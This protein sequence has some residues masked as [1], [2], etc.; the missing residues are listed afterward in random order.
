MGA[1]SRAALL[2]PHPMSYAG[3]ELAIRRPVELQIKTA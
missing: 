1:A 3:L 2:P